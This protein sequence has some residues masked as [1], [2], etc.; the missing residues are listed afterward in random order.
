MTAHALFVGQRIELRDF[1]RGRVL[2]RGPLLVSAG[3]SGCAVMFRYGIV[4]LYNLSDVEEMKFLADIRPLV[5]EPY[6]DI[7]R[8]TVEIELDPNAKEGVYESRIVLHAFDYELL[9]LIADVLAKSVALAYHEAAIRESFDRIEPL[10][11][12]LQKGG[13]GRHP[14]RTLI[15]YIGDMLSVQSRMVGRAEITDKPDLLWEYPLY[16]SLYARI[17][18]EY[19]LRERYDALDRKLELISRTAETLLGLLQENRTLR[20][21]WYIVILIVIEILL[22][23]YE[24]W[25]PF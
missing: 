3:A 2:A 15:K 18:D 16:E 17:E 25:H 22:T 20:V 1:E 9:Q 21:E 10:V 12:S 6:K 8:E 14:V 5:V 19:E 4:V 7:E 11:V 24:W 13:R 23:L